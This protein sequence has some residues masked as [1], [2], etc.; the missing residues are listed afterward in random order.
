MA[1][2][3]FPTGEVWYEFE[4]ETGLITPPK[5]KLKLKPSF[6]KDLIH[7][8]LRQ[9]DISKE[10]AEAGKMSR[11]EML[12]SFENSCEFA[13]KHVVG[14]ELEDQKGAQIPC[15]DPNKKKYLDPL[16]W[17][18][19]KDTKKYKSEAERI[20]NSRWLWSAIIEFIGDVKNFTKN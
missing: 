2:I 12:E 15:T 18:V 17:E 6:K 8:T 1:K 4:I 16:L 3:N 11:E 14:W 19:I 9:I 5:L 7:S 20:R 13:M 10:S